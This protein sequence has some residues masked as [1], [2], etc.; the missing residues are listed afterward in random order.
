MISVTIILNN[1]YKSSNIL[2]QKDN[3]I[4]ECSTWRQGSD[5]KTVTVISEF[6]DKE[7]LLSALYKLS[8]YKQQKYQKMGIFL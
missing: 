8:G 1:V 3:L 2:N 7:T 4:D 5:S 6:Y